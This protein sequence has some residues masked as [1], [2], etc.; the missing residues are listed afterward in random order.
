[1]TLVI[2]LSVAGNADCYRIVYSKFFFKQANS[3]SAGYQVEALDTAAFRMETLLGYLT[4]KT[5]PP[6]PPPRLV[7]VGK[8]HSRLQTGLS[9]RLTLL[10]AVAGSG[11]TTCLSSFFQT[12]SRTDKRAVW[13]TLDTSDNERSRFW[14]SFLDALASLD[15]GLS[16]TVS[17]MSESSWTGFADMDWL[18]QP[19]G[20]IAALPF[21]IFFVLDDYQKIS[22]EQISTDLIYWI[23][24]MPDTI[25]LAI[26]SRVP[27][28]FS[29]SRLRGQD[30]LVEIQSR[31]LFLDLAG[32]ARFLRQTKG[33]EVSQ[34]EVHA[35]FELTGG[36]IAGLQLAIGSL[37]GKDGESR[38]SLDSSRVNRHIRTYMV[39]EV[40]NQQED[41]LKLF[42]LRT[43]ILKR[44]SVSLCAEVAGAEKNGHS[45]ESLIQAGLFVAPLDDTGEWYSYHPL[46]AEA[47]RQHLSVVLPEEISQL[48]I[49]A[50]AWSERMRYLDDALDYAMSA[51]DDDRV[52]RLFER[53]MLAA[54]NQLDGETFILD[55][56]RVRG[57][58]KALPA[59]RYGEDLP[60]LLLNAW[61]NFV[62]S[63]PQES[64]GYLQRTRQSLS[65]WSINEK[66]A[67]QLI[68]GV[69]EILATIE[70]GNASMDGDYDRAVELSRNA[71][72]QL[73]AGSIWFR[74]TLLCL[75]GEALA[76]IGDIDE[77]MRSYAQAKAASAAFGGEQLEQYCSYQIGKLYLQR[78]Q[79][80]RAAETWGNAIP[81]HESE[82]K[83]AVF[84][85]G[86]LN[87]ALVRLHTIRGNI[88]EASRYLEQ[89]QSILFRTGNLFCQLE[90]QTAH[91]YLL[92]AQGF[93]AESLGIIATA[94]ERALSSYREIVPRSSAWETFICHARISLSSGDP[95]A[96]E[97]M[98]ATLGEL[99]APHEG[100]YRVQTDLIQATIMQATGKSKEALRSLNEILPE[101]E[102]I[103][104]PSL[105]ID[106]MVLRA[107][108]LHSLEQKKAAAIEFTLAVD[109]ADKEYYIQPFINNSPVIGE[110]LYRLFCEKKGGT[111]IRKTR[112]SLC[113]RLLNLRKSLFPELRINEMQTITNLTKREKDILKLL[114]K[115]MTKLEIADSLHISVN[116]VKTHVKNIYKKLD[117]HERTAAFSISGSVVE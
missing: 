20:Q 70:A 64:M 18:S 31:D 108:C 61:S 60:F 15:P 104:C 98:C 91:A 38:I 76:G 67:P 106:A 81:L 10:T 22:S 50:S 36:W 3:S 92:E 47:L 101:I 45:L 32:T 19:L 96:A 23:E 34:E 84:T 59:E 35:L 95:I 102:R 30:Q 2:V 86:L 90:L 111:A 69:E 58:L 6:P 48:Y 55:E 29:L 89:A 63:R 79:L 93:Y 21:E 53:T 24:H 105:M 44:L 13:L 107:V 85:L 52:I 39:D 75:L 33:L 73:R 51:K 56:W 54:F 57:W 82:G 94:S 9:K 74:V 41:S 17:A 83:L 1:M 14:V 78:G 113:K 46:F 97:K 37:Q 88:D 71:L 72:S 27:P 43:S 49:R 8:L 25:H 99:I 62:A 42:L 117:V 115:G 103:I 11:K 109:A 16:T 80:E 114:E 77:S 12:V 87:V 7:P 65:T 68:S 4:N 5:I 112:R 28:A 40:L 110:L 26:A 66:D 100:Y 116:T